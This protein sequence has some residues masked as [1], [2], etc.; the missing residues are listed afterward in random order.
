MVARYEDHRRAELRGFVDRLARHGL[1]RAG[2]DAEEATALLA[3]LTSP[4][5]FDALLGSGTV[6]R[7]TE[8]LLLLILTTLGTEL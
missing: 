1:L 2:L 7:A 8:R 4:V 6:E 5:F 3:P